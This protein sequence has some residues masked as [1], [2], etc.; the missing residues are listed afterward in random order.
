M[1]GA[2]PQLPPAGL[3]H[4]THTA[5]K[6]TSW[7][8]REQHP[9]DIGLLMSS[10]ALHAP[11]AACCSCNLLPAMQLRLLGSIQSRK[12]TQSSTR[13]DA[14]LARHGAAGGGRGYLLLED[15]L[16][17]M[18]WTHSGQCIPQRLKSGSA[19]NFILV[20]KLRCLLCYN[21]QDEIEQGA[22]KTKQA[23]NHK[24]STFTGSLVA[25]VNAIPR[26]LKSTVQALAHA[27]MVRQ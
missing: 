6:P 19:Q 24:S 23:T 9:A 1:P 25:F 20:L 27:S 8:R 22:L 4:K 5:P 16:L 13:Q 3:A 12:E 10:T 26:I 2:T 21:R 11:R 7:E 17:G 15:S 14:K 18:P